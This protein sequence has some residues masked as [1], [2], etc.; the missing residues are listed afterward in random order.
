M[1]FWGQF[2]FQVF[3]FYCNYRGPTIGEMK[4]REFQLINGNTGDFYSCKIK[5]QMVLVEVHVE[6]GIVHINIPGHPEIL[7]DK[8]QVKKKNDV[9]PTM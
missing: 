4:D 1:T 6:N 3:S 7:V 9:R 8:A 5:P 2:S